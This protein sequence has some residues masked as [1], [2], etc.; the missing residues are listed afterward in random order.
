MNP[1][2]FKQDKPGQMDVIMTQLWMVHLTKMSNPTTLSRCCNG[3][4]S[5]KGRK[6][7][8]ACTLPANVTLC[9]V[10]QGHNFRWPDSYVCRS[11][12]GH[13]M[14]RSYW[15]LIT[16]QQF[17][18]A[19]PEPATEPRPI[20][21]QPELVWSYITNTTNWSKKIQIHGAALR[22]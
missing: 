3:W 1:L 21:Y 4:W 5:E 18:P 22:V 11:P 16:S 14:N 10:Y 20:L 2:R 15:H 8:K 9:I 12:E 7:N 13:R 6:Y 19:E 17:E